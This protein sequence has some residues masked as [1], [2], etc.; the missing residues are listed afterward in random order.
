MRENSNIHVHKKGIYEKYI[1]RPQDFLL[2]LIAIVIFSPVLIIVAI[3]VKKKLGTPVIFKQKRPGLNGEIFTLYKF[4]TMTD[5]KDSKGNL[6][7][8]DERMTD[9]GRKLRRT[10]LDELPELFNILEGTCSI[11]GPRP[12]LVKYLNRYNSHQNRRHE[13]KPGLTGYAQVHGRNS[14]SWEEKFDMDVYYVD[15]I[16]FFNDWKIIF[17]TVLTVLR[18]EGITSEGSETMEEFMGKEKEEK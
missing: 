13:V 12:L 4:R 9:F 2:S 1:K 5:E 14:I 11:C 18:R 10:S 6:L 17:Q 8:D 3:L 7:S 16:G 15:H